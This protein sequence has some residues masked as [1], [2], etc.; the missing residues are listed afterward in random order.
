MAFHPFRIFQKHRRVMLAG[1][2]LLAM[3]TF[4]LCGSS[5][6]VGGNF[7]SEVLVR[8]GF[9]KS[10]HVEV[11]KLD[12]NKITYEEMLALQRQRLIAHEFM[13]AATNIAQENIV[14]DFKQNL[15]T[16]KLEDLQQQ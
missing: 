3:V 15:P 9:R 12:G 2:T 14:R 16:L 5:S 1:V 11:C 6:L 7:F 13:S 4:V 8:F 10:Q